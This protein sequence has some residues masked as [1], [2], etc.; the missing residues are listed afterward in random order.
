MT[1]EIEKRLATRD[2]DEWVELL[3]AAGVP[4]GPV[5]NVEQS[6]ADPQVQTLPVVAPVKHPTYGDQRL[7]GHGFNLERTPPRI[8]S[9][10][11]ERGEHTDEILGELG[12]GMQE[13][14]RLR[15]DRVV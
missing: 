7:V 1:V 11:P 12:Y 5:L 3:T 14:E 6:F 13:I 9:A 4:A 8:C 2:A 15:A 10:A